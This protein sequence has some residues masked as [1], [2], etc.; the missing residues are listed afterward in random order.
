MGFSRHYYER[1]P[2]STRALEWL[3]DNPDGATF[4]YREGEL[5]ESSG[6]ADW[7]TMRALERSQDV[8]QFGYRPERFTKANRGGEHRITFKLSEH[9]RRGI[10][11]D[12]ETPPNEKA[13]S[14]VSQVS[15]ET[16]DPAVRTLISDAATWLRTQRAGA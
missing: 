13:A 8:G 1:S 16:H 2:A 4:L 5:V 11:W 6:P 9:T 14:L 7:S 10:Q 15:M 12:R 3:Y